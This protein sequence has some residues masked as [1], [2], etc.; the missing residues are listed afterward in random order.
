MGFKPWGELRFGTSPMQYQYTGQYRDSYINLYWYGSR[1]YD[2]SLCRFI[3]PDAIIPSNG[4]NYS[5]LT[6]DYH[7]IQF[8]EQLNQENRERLGDSQAKTPSVPTNPLAFDRYSYANS[9]PLAYSDPDGHFAF[10]VPL[11]AGALIGGGISTAAYLIAAKA[12]GQ[13]AT[14]AGAAGAFAGGQLQVLLA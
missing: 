5:P 1:W 2:D 7:E 13:E 11:L 9:N 8:L 4:G 3:Q 6:V 14:W 12:S 10:L